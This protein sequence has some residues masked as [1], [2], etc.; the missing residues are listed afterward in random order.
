MVEQ[1]LLWLK[2]LLAAHPYLAPGLFIAVHVALA[3][4]LL[5]CSPMTLLAGVLWGG[6]Q[7]F[8]LSLAGALASMAVTFWL[9]R[10]LL[11]E[12]LERFLLRRYPKVA[13]ILGQAAR[14][15]WKLIA[16][17][18]LNP[19][20]PGSSLGYPFGLTRIPFL[21]YLGLSFVFMLPLQLL[22]VQTGDSAIGAI[23]ST[24]SLHW[25]LGTVSALLVL[26]LCGKHLARKLSK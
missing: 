20:V 17:V 9:A 15:D 16:A 10:R 21:R 1:F 11:R 18:Q 14:H 23:T 22:L 26:S 6:V 13:A 4:C 12:R 19:V 5:P 2:P 25:L 24:R 8:V 3:A 7:G